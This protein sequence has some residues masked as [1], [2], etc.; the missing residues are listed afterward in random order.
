MKHVEVELLLQL[1]V[2]I[3]NLN[4]VTRVQLLLAV[5]QFRA[6][7]GLVDARRVLNRSLV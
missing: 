5:G 1:F 2:N 4:A 7:K 6:I 3:A